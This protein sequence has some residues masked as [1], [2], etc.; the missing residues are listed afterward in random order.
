[1]AIDSEAFK[2][3]ADAF[4]TR[5]GYLGTKAEIEEGLEKV[6]VAKTLEKIAKSK[7]I[8]SPQCLEVNLLYACYQAEFAWN[9]NVDRAERLR[10][11]LSR[12]GAALTKATAEMISVAEMFEKHPEI[13]E[14][15]LA[16]PDGPVEKADLPITP[17]RSPIAPIEAVRL[18]PDALRKVVSAL[19][20]SSANGDK[21]FSDMT[22]CDVAGPFLFFHRQEERGRP[23]GPRSMYRR[24]VE[25]GL[26]FHLTYLLRYFSGG[27]D[28]PYCTAKMSKAGELVISG[29]MIS[30]GVPHND[31]TAHLAN[32]I[33]DV[34][35]PKD[36][37][38]GAK[39]GDRLKTLLKPSADSNKSKKKDTRGEPFTH[40]E[41]CGWPE[42]S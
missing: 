33:F 34:K 26:L 9:E 31:I 19:S 28:D 4:K 10:K 32:A 23:S 37:I 14:A 39:V 42:V 27:A 12:G 30:K 11:R 18:I 38:S 41:F 16:Y 40:L 17:Y 20:L 5:K 7:K 15:A 2:K 22:A 1:M 29:P 13:I 35:Y 25:N 21:Y 6:P 24:L 36:A 8:T 3:W